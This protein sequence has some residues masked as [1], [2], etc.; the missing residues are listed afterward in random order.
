MALTLDTMAYDILQTIRNGKVVDD[1]NVDIR[2]IRL[3]IKNSR[4]VW[5]KN[6]LSKGRTISQRFIQDLGVLNMQL[7]NVSMISTISTDYKLL[8]TTIPIPNTIEC[9]GIPTL[10]RV[11]PAMINNAAY[12]VVPYERLPYVGNGRFNTSRIFAFWK[13][14]YIYLTTK[15]SSLQFSGM[16]KINV[17]AVLA[18]PTEAATFLKTDGTPCYKPTDDYPLTEQLYV[19]MKDII[20]K[21]D[22]V[23]LLSTKADDLNNATD[24]T[25]KK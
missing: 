12:T 16:Q 19:Y 22:I 15:L 7:V 9:N 5:V 6:E 8:R 10:T 13:D 2:D 24:D 4:A 25:G 18:D 23:T 14:N 21:S 1:D 20:L 17:R 11:G 3:W